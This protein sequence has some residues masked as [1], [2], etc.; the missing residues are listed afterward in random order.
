MSRFALACA[1]A[2]TLLGAACAQAQAPFVSSSYPLPTTPVGD[3]GPLGA[4]FNPAAWGLVHRFA[5]D[6]WWADRTA[7]S[8]SP[9]N[10]GIAAGSKLGF[11]AWR[12]DFPTPLGDAYVVDYQAGFG[13]GSP[14]S[15]F[16][17]TFG[18]SGGNGKAAGRDNYIA[19]GTIQ[20]PSRFLSLGLA[21]RSELR[22]AT[23]Q[24][25]LLSAA[26]RPLGN[27]KLVVFGDYSLQGGEVWNQG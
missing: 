9:G 4:V 15:L 5:A 7:T 24:G 12:T 25:L 23:G 20:R 10:W 6:V 17:G 26:A 19:L 11:S 3:E 8:S 13:A 1:V 22:R 14:A 27:P 18:W 21:G 16:G 2:V